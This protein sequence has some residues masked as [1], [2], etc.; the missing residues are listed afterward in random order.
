M[1]ARRSLTIVLTAAAALAACAASA[2]AQE[3]GGL[4][5]R[6]GETGCHDLYPLATAFPLLSMFFPGDLSRTPL[7]RYEIRGLPEGQGF[8]PF[9]V[10]VDGE[11]RG[12]GGVGPGGLV[13]AQV[14]LAG[15]GAAEVRVTSGDR[16]LAS[17]TYQS[18]C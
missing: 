9:E 15:A 5:I 16:V 18:R 4:D 14:A 11:R 2:S 10:A 3:S 7:V 8:V 6:L 17:R 12:V 1:L 13:S